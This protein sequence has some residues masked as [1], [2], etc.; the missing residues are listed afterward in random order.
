MPRVDPS[1]ADAGSDAARDKK[2]TAEAVAKVVRSRGGYSNLPINSKVFLDRCGWTSVEGCLHVFRDCKILRL[3]CNALKFL[4]GLETLAKLRFLYLQSNQLRSLGEALAQNM[5]LDT[6]DLTANEFQALVPGEIPQSVTNLY[7]AGNRLRGPEALRGLSSLP[8]LQ[9]LDLSRNM[10][11]EDEDLEALTGEGASCRASLRVLYLAGNPIASS[12]AYR[13][14]IIARLP[15]LTYLDDQPVDALERVCAEAWMRGGREAMLAAKFAHAEARK[16]AQRR[17]VAEMR[18]MRESGSNST[19]LDPSALLPLITLGP[20]SGDGR[21]EDARECTICQEGLAAGESVLMLPCAHH[22]H[23]LCIRPWLALFKNTC[24]ICRA[25]I[26]TRDVTL[27][28]RAFLATTSAAFSELG[29][30]ANA[31]LVPDRGASETH[32]G[33]SSSCQSRYNSASSVDDASCSADCSSATSSTGAWAR[34]R[35]LSMPSTFNG[36]VHRLG[37]DLGDGSSRSNLDI[38]NKLLMK[39]WGKRVV[40]GP[41]EK[42][43]E[44]EKRNIERTRLQREIDARKVERRARGEPE[45]EE[46]G[47][48]RTP[49]FLVTTLGV[50]EGDDGAIPLQVLRRYKEDRAP[51]RKGAN[52]FKAL[53]ERGESGTQ[54]EEV[55]NVSCKEPGTLSDTPSGLPC[56]CE[57]NAKLA[58]AVDKFARSRVVLGR[59]EQYRIFSRTAEIIRKFPDQIHSCDDI[60]GEEIGAGSLSIID[61]Y[62]RRGYVWGNTL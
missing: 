22:Y 41:A 33:S 49:E 23:A 14:T 30:D 57:K 42:A 37:I 36:E 19:G 9:V 60:K 48:L 50:I 26:L 10:L 45:E 3:E 47:L 58:D 4:S 53:L 38:V 32:D 59:I 13:R 15:C 61:E 16:E 5:S 25:P 46:D 55:D 8:N 21:G 24:P 28:A 6:I 29:V 7:A 62:L 51:A 31:I 39:R 43:A 54:V 17:Q 18:R 44:R 56:A 12:S 1:P 40:K 11:S 20:E 2:M 52:A 35:E 27:G 34:A